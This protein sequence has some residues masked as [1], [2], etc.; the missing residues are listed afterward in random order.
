MKHNWIPDRS[1]AGAWLGMLLVLLLAGC[2][3]TSTLPRQYDQPARVQS[4][5]LSLITAPGQAEDSLLIVQPEAAGASRWIQ[6]NA[7]GAPLARLSLRN[8]QWT[9]DGFAPPN[10]R[11]R[12][13]FEAIIAAQIPRSQWP[14][15]YP[16]IDIGKTD[17]SSGATYT[18]SRQGQMLWSLQLPP[19]RTAAGKPQADT[20]AVT[21]AAA[22]TLPDRS[23]WNLTPLPARP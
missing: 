21:A 12:Q 2:A 7:L 17:S 13:L 4:Y 3:A 16:D 9:T 1:L 5:K 10:P 22:I 8:G 15:A 6:T 11:A 20:S 18:F 14:D 23:Q 19:T